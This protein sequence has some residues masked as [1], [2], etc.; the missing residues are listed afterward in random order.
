MTYTAP[1]DDMRFVLDELCDLPALSELPGYQEATPELTGQILNEAAKLAS[2]VWAPL[3]QPG[4]REGCRLEN[5]VV[6]TPAG[7]AEAYRAYTDGGWNGLAIDRDH[8]GMGLPA[9]LAT[10]V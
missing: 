10:A 4:D 9:T 6:R 5:G 2:Q 3:N 1:L 8:G 7:F